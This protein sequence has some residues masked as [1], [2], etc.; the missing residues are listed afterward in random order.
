MIGSGGIGDD[1]GAWLW[2][3]AVSGSRVGAFGYPRADPD[4]GL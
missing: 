3:L 1:G 2:M 4:T